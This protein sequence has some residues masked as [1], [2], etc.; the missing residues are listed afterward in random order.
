MARI[1]AD[2]HIS[3]VIPTCEEVMYLAA[4]REARLPDMPLLAPS[5]ATLAEAHDKAAFVAC[6]QAAGLPAP[7]TQRVSSLE[8]LA[9]IADP[10]ALVFKPRWSRFA[11]RVLIRPGRTALRH[12]QPTVDDPWIAQEF[13]AGE[14]VCIYALAVAGRITALSAYSPAWRAGRGAG[15]C[16]AAQAGEDILSLAQTYAAATA[17]TGQLAF[18]AIRRPDGV[19]VPIECNPRATSGLHFFRDASAFWPALTGERDS[20]L[21]PD[22]P[23]Y[24]AVRQ[25]MWL[26]ALPRALAEGKLSQFRADMARAVEAT[27]FPGCPATALAQ[28]V[29]AAGLAAL[30]IRRRRSLISAATWGI[31]YA[32]ASP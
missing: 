11:A 7:A 22:G 4:L 6:A 31:E 19:L 10:T 32:G 14:E 5:V 20:V 15:I 3:L 18:D 21:A 28:L 1:I 27:R 2:E 24:L 9:R 29:S 23:D 12:L 30:A 16:F 13:I 8:D 26:F 25:A 17:W